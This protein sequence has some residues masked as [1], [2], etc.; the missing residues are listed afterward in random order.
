MPLGPY[1][2]EA[3]PA[4]NPERSGGLTVGWSDFLGSIFSKLNV[5]CV[6]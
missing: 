5:G 1:N 2:V 6:F 3:Q 4:G